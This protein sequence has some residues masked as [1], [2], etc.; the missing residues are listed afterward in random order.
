[1][2]LQKLNKQKQTNQHQKTP[3]L[4]V[5]QRALLLLVPAVYM[6]GFAV[7]EK[8]DGYDG[9]GWGLLTLVAAAVLIVA[10]ATLVVV[11]LILV[12]KKKQ[13]LDRISVAVFVLMLIGLLYNLLD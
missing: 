9:L 13:K 8:I 10:F 11:H 1:M 5:V 4:I 7:A 3:K 6:A 2:P 12:Y